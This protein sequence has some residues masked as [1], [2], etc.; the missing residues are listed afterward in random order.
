VSETKLMDCPFCGETPERTVLPSG[1]RKIACDG[2]GIEGSQSWWEKR[3]ATS[4]H[5]D[6][7][8]ALEA[9][10]KMNMAFGESSKNQA[11]AYYAFVDRKHAVWYDIEAVL[12]KAKPNLEEPRG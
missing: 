12:N 11:A 8:S 6:L 9:A 5:H 4:L 1:F 2:C 10:V 3:A 7:V